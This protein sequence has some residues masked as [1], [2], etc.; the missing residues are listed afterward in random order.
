MT[1][2]KNK[3]LYRLIFYFV[4]S[5]IVF[6]AVIGIIFTVLFSTYN[7]DG[8]KNELERRARSIAETLSGYFEPRKQG[9]SNMGHG[10]GM[11]GYG[12]YLRFIEGIAMSD[13][14]I[15]DNSLEQ[16]TFGHG[17]S[18]IN[19]KDLPEGADQTVMRAFA[20]ETSVSENFSVFL[21][22]PTI[23]AATPITLSDGTVAGAVLLHSQVSD[24][25]KVTS[26]GIVTLIISM[27]A[28]VF[29]SV[30]VAFLLSSHFTKP[31]AKM[32]AAALK[33]GK[34][35]YSVSTGVKQSDEIGELALVID[36]MAKKLALSS[37]ESVKLENLRRDFIANISHELRTP[38]T[39]IRGSLEALC[40]GV[41]TDSKKVTEYHQQMFS[42]S[43][44]LERLVSD[45]LDLARLQNPDFK[46]EAQDVDFKSIIE[47]VIRSM[48]RIADS[49]N[50][51]LEFACAGEIFIINGD[52][53]RLRQMLIV[54][55]DNAVK[56]SPEGE[57]VYITLVKTE[58]E[59]KLAI[60][61]KGCGVPPEDVPHIFDRF[62]KQRSEKNKTGTGLGLAIAK[63][64]ADRHG[65]IIEV[66]S[67]KGKGS[68]F[69]VTFKYL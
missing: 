6:A 35:D 63:Q 47:D 48:K 33:V 14:W 8:H 22:T 39:V 23:T 3:I 36:N 69:V 44:Y 66:V 57:S 52:Y 34:G 15:V 67:G 2:L 5:F 7:M 43:L 58:T 1:S 27:A 12:A 32:K 26:G 62:Y 51:V 21:E 11:G 55:L 64:I 49:K 40:D 46:I 17:Q 59:V 56:F 68:A 13:I 24:V 50:I 30:Y 9:G 25:Y 16:I 19:L 60:R 38:V 61:D 29:I 4:T 65:A 20:G 41:V 31:L 10:N 42:E 45:L 53:A 37:E 18:N 28:A 54:I